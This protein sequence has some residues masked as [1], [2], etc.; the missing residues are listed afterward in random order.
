M[1]TSILVLGGTGTVGSRIA[2]QLPAL[3]N[4]TVLIASR[5]KNNSTTTT[6]PQ[7]PRSSKVEHVTFD[8][9]DPST[10]SNPFSSSSSSAP[11]VR[12]VYLIA[13]PTFD[14]DS[15][16]MSFIDFARDRGVR[17]F[18][19]QS[20]SPIEAGGPVMGKVHAYLRELGQRGEV[21]WGV[22]RPSWFQG[23][24]FIFFLPT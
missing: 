4:S 12:A 10:W 9:H 21:E 18:V 20:A 22:L 3:S 5:N 6:P 8:W 11:P 2:R 23:A 15:L 16:M 24:F 17:R 13:P 19:L 14:A 1:T 7:P